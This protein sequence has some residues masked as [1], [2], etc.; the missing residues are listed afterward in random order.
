MHPM[1]WAI[2]SLIRRRWFA[3]L[4][5]AFEIWKA[6]RLVRACLVSDR[7]VIRLLKIRVLSPGDCISLRTIAIVDAVERLSKA[8]GMKLPPPIGIMRDTLNLDN[9][10]AIGNYGDRG[11]IALTEGLLYVL[12]MD[13]VEAVIAHEIGHLVHRDV[14]A[15]ILRDAAISIIR[16]LLLTS[17]RRFN[18]FAW[19]A[20]TIVLGEWAER[21]ETEVEKAADSVGRDLK[22]RDEMMWA[23]EKLRRA[24]RAS[25]AS[26][27]QLRQRLHALR[28]IRF[29]QRLAPA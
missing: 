17:L 18:V 25:K 27:K 16:I 10:F 3:T 22:G 12:S 29:A 4:V 26:C 24:S 8:A 9:A 11:L 2:L 21:R 5:L 23:L 28:P 7:A 6:H 13:E 14:P 1:A 20:A 19:L 15:M